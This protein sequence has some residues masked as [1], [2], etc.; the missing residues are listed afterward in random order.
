[1]VLN[2]TAKSAAAPT[3]AKAGT[4][5]TL[6]S[7][8]LT[9]LLPGEE[10]DAYLKRHLPAYD[11]VIYVGDG[12]NDFC[13][14]LRLRRS[15]K[16]TD[17]RILLTLVVAR[18]WFS[19]DATGVSNPESPRRVKSWGSNAR[20]STGQEPGRWKRSLILLRSYKRALD[21]ITRWNETG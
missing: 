12:S 5:I 9:G 21:G 16:F 17:P 6:E 20:S 2:T 19:A 13:P 14:V 7:R 3:C 10:L 1:M 4:K 15:A 11:S 8:F 18:I